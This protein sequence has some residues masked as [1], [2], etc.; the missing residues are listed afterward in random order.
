[1][2]RHVP[3]NV[4]R[5]QPFT[6]PRLREVTITALLA[7]VAVL[8]FQ[9]SGSH[10]QAPD[11]LFFS[12]GFLVTGNYVVGSVDLR[13][14]LHPAVNGFATGVLQIGNV[15]PTQTE[16]GNVIPDNPDGSPA[17]IVAAYLYWETIH[18]NAPPFDPE[19]NPSPS[20][21]VEF[22]D[23]SIVPTAV[24]I[25][26]FQLGLTEN[27][28]QCWGSAGQKGS[29]VSTFRADVLHLLPKLLD[30][31]NEWT[32]KYV[33]TDQDLESYTQQ[34][35]VDAWPEK[36]GNQVYG[37]HTVTLPEGAGDQATQSGGATLFLVYR[38]ASEPLRKI[39]VFDGIYHKPQ[40]GTMSQTLRGFYQSAGGP[41]RL[42]FLA[43]TGGNNQSEVVSFNGAPI[44]SWVNAFPQTSPSSDRSW[45]DAR[46]VVTMP[47]GVAPQNGYT[48]FGQ[49]VLTS[50]TN[51]SSNPND[52]QAYAAVF[53]S[54]AVLDADPNPANPSIPGDGIPDGLENSETGLKDPPTTWAPTGD[55][56][57]KLKQM[58][59]GS[60]QR[61]IF[62]EFND[63][64]AAGADPNADPPFPGTTYGS[65]TAPYKILPGPPPSIV[66][67][68]VTD[69][70][71]HRHTPTP[72]VLKLVGDA[73]AAQGIRPH[74]DV[75]DIA[76][77]HALGFIQHTDWEDDY[78]E[79]ITDLQGNPCPAN[80][81]GDCYLVPSD[82]ARGGEILQ[83]KPCDPTHPACH[84]PA[85]PGTVHWKLGLQMIRDA[86]VHN[87]GSE[88]TLA[89][90]T[91]PEDP[92]F[93][94]WDN[95]EHRRRFDFARRG[96]F[97]YV[98]NAHARGKPR[99]LPCLFNGNP[100]PYDLDNVPDP[101]GTP[102]ACSVG[103]PNFEQLEY[104]VPSSASGIADYPGGNALVTLG[105][106]EEFVGRPFMR[107]ATT[108]HEEGHN[109]SL[110]HGGFEPL[111]GN[112]SLGTATYVEPNCKPQYLSSMSYLY[113][114]HGLFDDN[115]EMNIDYSGTAYPGFVETSTLS[116]QTQGTLSPTPNY[117]PAWFA[118][119]GAL[120]TELNV[121][122]AK[123][124][125]NGVKFNPASPPAPRFRVHVSD[126]SDVIDWNG[127]KLINSSLFQQ[128]V[129]FDNVVTGAPKQLNG[130][131]DWPNI[132]LD[133]IGAAP[134][135]LLPGS[136]ENLAELGGNLTE[137]GGNLT[138]LGGNLTELGGNLAEL[139]GNVEEMNAQHAGELGKGR[140]YRVTA[141]VINDPA[142][143][144]TS[145]PFNAACHRAEF[146][147]KA[148]PFGTFSAYQ[149]QRKRANAGDETFANVGTTSTNYFKDL[150]ELADG[151]EYEYRVQGIAVDGNSE[152]SSCPEEPT[153]CKARVI[154]VN[155]APAAKAPG[156]VHY[157]VILVKG[158]HFEPAPGVLNLTVDLD[159]PPDFRGRRVTK[160]V[161][162]TGELPAPATANLTNGTLTLNVDGSFTY[163]PFK[164]NFL[165]MDSFVFKA[166]DGL[167]SATTDPPPVALSGESANVTITINVVSK[168]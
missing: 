129:N 85:Y 147:F 42:T 28:A 11:A 163:I 144:P 138:E 1:M 123:R 135:G 151:V 100:A 10:A 73:Y 156:G 107:A 117:Q 97:H 87:D 106:W 122:P 12:R 92:N 112:K 20:T 105:L 168:K 99:S 80:P 5:A 111:W 78:G 7:V 33:V 56:L 95:G 25:T 86:P 121:S 49:E 164:S 120:A 31:N 39:T 159:S 98:L 93:F 52:C 157:T 136:A 132:R 6:A 59:G 53:F 115:D 61:D 22:R 150:N 16:P 46:R 108:F 15:P 152:W 21:G 141:S 82:L 89:Q 62:I 133:Q 63:M 72:E 130:F 165:G 35:G 103:N 70:V 19:T 125:C 113:V 69:T 116:D 4:R 161:T 145:A 38:L 43:G 142:S 84:F 124:F 90:V 34:T 162:P 60:D 40:T 24:K 88:L 29:Y 139:G 37:P 153:V 50:I 94:D 131:N 18:E 3:P 74:F 104:H 149:V 65:L 134:T 30:A 158:T 143:C 55:E 148:P 54:T 77:Y 167:S 128:D 58:G 36:A 41:A 8:L 155:A 71:G 81:S 57:P 110:S 14:D 51:A 160:L 13:P 17:D 127:D 44:V 64:W 67:V 154:G 9:Q 23:S 119:A 146:T 137:L 68:S 47:A 96:V 48:G 45:G 83:E 102:D 66:T 79:V 109:L 2:K 114:A 91:D 118:P 26:S 126:T 166:D 27:P 101:D 140:P 76:T 32:G 75:G